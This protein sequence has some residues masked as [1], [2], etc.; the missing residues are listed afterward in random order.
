[1]FSY[2][3]M[4][5]VRQR[6]EKLVSNT[7]I[8]NGKPIGRIVSNSRATISYGHDSIVTY[9][10]IKSEQRCN[11][12]ICS[13]PTY[14]DRWKLFKPASYVL[15]VLQMSNYAEYLFFWASSSCPFHVMNNANE[16]RTFFLHRLRFRIAKPFSMS[17]KNS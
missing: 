10:Y 11:V 12:A 5:S 8:R 1:M 16:S 4:T 6:H 9:N 2:A 15:Y 7:E 13:V 3:W 14:N 17:D